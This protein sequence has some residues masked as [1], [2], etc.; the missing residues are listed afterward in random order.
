VKTA[1]A[2]REKRRP[3]TLRLFA[4]HVYGDA[5]ARTPAMAIEPNWQEE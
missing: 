2:S 5:P 1:E 4:Q 3:E